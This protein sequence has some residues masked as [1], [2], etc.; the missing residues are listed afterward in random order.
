MSFFSKFSLGKKEND[1]AIEQTPK[2]APRVYE[3]RNWYYDR[4]ETLIVQRN[5]LFLLAILSIVASMV[6]VFFV[7]KVT[8]SKTVEPMVVEVEDKTGITNIVNPFSDRTW[9]SDKAVSEYFLVMYLRDR[10]TY[11]AASYNYNFSTVVRLLSSGEVYSQFKSYIT[12]PKTNPVALYAANN[13]TTLKIRSIQHLPDSSS[14]DH[15][16]QIRFSVIETAGNK[17]QFN[18]IVSVYW[19]YTQMQ[20]TFN[21]RMVNPL[22]FQ[23]KFYSVT[24][25]VS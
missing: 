18:K 19:N 16:V 14:G 2:D 9:T 10:E 6:C 22:G 17:A 1:Q 24:N 12:D 3:A 23:I 5:A 21:E 13:S 8:L 7:G 25:D 20:M 4:Y 15:T 11:D